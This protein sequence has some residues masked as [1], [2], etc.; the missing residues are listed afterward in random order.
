MRVS[1]D[2]RMDTLLLVIHENVPVARTVEVKYGLVD[3]DEAG[4]IVAV[5]LLGASALIEKAA[6][7]ATQPDMNTDLLDL[8]S[9][10]SREARDKLEQPS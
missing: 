7:M 9:Q 6:D 10:I 1:Y 4:G 2:K 8:L 3:V 5:E